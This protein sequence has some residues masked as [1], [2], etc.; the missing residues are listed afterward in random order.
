MK[1]FSVFFIFFIAN[2]TFSQQLFSSFSIG[3]NEGV[4]MAHTDV[5]GNNI[6]TSTSFD[7][8][9]YYTPNINLGMDYQFGKLKGGP[10]KYTKYFKNNFQCYTLKARI[11]SAQFANVFTNRNRFN[12]YFGT[13]IG[14]LKST[15]TDINLD[16]KLEGQKYSGTNWIVPIDIGTDISFRKRI[17][18]NINYQWN[19]S[20]TDLSDGYNP[21]DANNKSNDYFSYLSLGL[22]FRLG[23]IKAYFK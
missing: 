15:I 3:V 23:K 10:D 17:L 11:Y 1:Y 20:F 5:K 8:Y 21:N 22:K 12:Y 16:P 18:L 19:V 9:Y 4:V 7:F 13:G 2:K 14:Q 6:N